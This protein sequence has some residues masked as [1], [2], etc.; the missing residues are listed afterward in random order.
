[1]PT[2]DT[3]QELFKALG[4]SHDEARFG[5]ALRRLYRLYKAEK[6]INAADEDQVVT[7][8]EAHR[9]MGKWLKEQYYFELF[10]RTYPL[11]E[12]TIRYGDRPDFILEGVRKIGVE[13]T[14]FFLEDGELPE[15]EQVQSPWREAVVSEARRIYCANGGKRIELSF[16]F[17]K[18]Q[19]IRDQCQLA[20]KIAKLARSVEG[21]PTGEISREIFN[22]IP[23]I[24][25]VYLNPEEYG[26]ARWR[27]F[28]TYSGQLMS[29]T[30]LQEIVKTKESK[31]RDYEYCD[32]YWL[33]VVVDF[34]NRAQDQEIRIDDFGKI[35]STVF[36]KV[37]VFRTALGHV[38]EAR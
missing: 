36:E 8:N 37:I 29:V 20:K 6:G 28:Q 31:L 33:L 16:S 9:R 38:F 22:E 27:V 26:D 32:A 17:D 12:G 30:K 10:R 35:D 24:S 18:A 15:S 7:P 4:Q 34:I 2:M 21:L 25:F 5:E 1:M 13:L 11:P 14:N 3:K 23:E 19:P